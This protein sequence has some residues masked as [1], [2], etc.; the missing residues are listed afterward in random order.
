MLT[1]YKQAGY[2]WTGTIVIQQHVSCL[3]GQL[4]C[5]NHLCLSTCNNFTLYM[6]LIL[7]CFVTWLKRHM[8]VQEVNT[9]SQSKTN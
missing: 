5:I 2:N 6:V 1:V 7:L 4:T 3:V 9:S 8:Y